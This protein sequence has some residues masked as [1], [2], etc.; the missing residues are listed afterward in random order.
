MKKAA[1]LLISMLLLAQ[2]CTNLFFNPQK[3]FAANP[4]VS[5]NEYKNVYFMSSDGVRLHGWFIKA[6]AGKKG[7][8]IFLHGYSQNISIQI[9]K[10]LWLTSE[11]Y[12]VFA[13]DY[14]GYGRSNGTPSLEGVHKDTNAAFKTIFDMAG[15]KGGKVFVLGQSLGGA[16]AVY[17]VANS[18]Y[19]DRI[20]GLIIDCAFSSYRQ[21]AKDKISQL[22]VSW[23]LI[24]LS[25]LVE[26]D[27]SPE[28]W[29]DKIGD[30]PV[31]IIH[32]DKDEAVPLKHAFRLFEAADE[33]K[34]LWIVKG[35]GHVLSF[36]DE[37]IKKRLVAFLTAA[38]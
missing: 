38:R 29:V 15:T 17:S 31:V 4:T 16:I 13:F 12:D 34:E 33:P 10:V 21:I 14:R 1:F 19:K 20:K 18:P 6:K 26:D 25:A 8:V 11:G 7:T 2:G 22:P 37:S 36:T 3:E 30:I 32:G 9:D 24:Y 35:K 28:K 5:A 23:P 27:F